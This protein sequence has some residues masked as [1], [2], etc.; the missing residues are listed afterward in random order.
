MR[1][2]SI[3]VAILAIG[4][5]S[6]LRAGEVVTL[7]PENFDQYIPAGKETDGL[8]GDLCMRND[9]IVAI[10]GKADRLR[11]ANM[12]VK[13]VGGM[14][15]DLTSRTDSNDQ[16]SAFYPCA[17]NRILTGPIDFTESKGSKEV[18][19]LRY[20]SQPVSGQPDLEVLYELKDGQ[21][22]ISVTTVYTNSSD[23]EIVIDPQDHIRADGECTTGVD[24]DLRLFWAQD[25][26]WGQAYGIVLADTSWQYAQDKRIL[27]Y[28]PSAPTAVSSKEP[29]SEKSAADKKENPKLPAQKLAA[30]QSLQIQ[31]WI[32]PASDTF[33]VRQKA[34]ELTNQT[35]SWKPLSIA[36]RDVK[37]PVQDCTIELQTS[38]GKSLAKARV[39]QLTSTI[40][41][42]KFDLSISAQGRKTVKQQ[43]DSTTASPLEIA[44]PLPGYVKSQITDE[45]GLPIACKCEIRGL[46][47]L[48]NPNFGPNSAIFGVGNLQYTPNGIFECELLPG[49]YEV[50][51]SHGL[52][53]DVATQRIEIAAGKTTSLQAKLVRSVKTPGWISADFHSH[54]S[55]SGD[56]TSNQRGRVL[57][58][59]SEHIEFAPC[60]E[61]N[62]ID[63]YEEHLQALEATNRMATCTG[64]ELTGSLLPVNHQNAFPLI[65]YPRTQ[66]NGG[67][68]TDLDPIAQIERLA[69]W[70][71][72]SDKLVQMNHPNLVQIIGDRDM[73]GKADGGFE[74]MFGFTDVIEVHP[75]QMIFERPTSL[76]ARDKDR[77]NPIF[78]WLQM[79]NL[80]YRITGVVNTDSHWNFHGSGWL[81]NYIRS[82]SDEPSQQDT[83]EL[84]HACEKGKVLMTNGPYLEVVGRCQSASG[85]QSAELGDTLS[86]SDGKVTLHIRVQCANWV[87]VNRVQVFVNGQPL[88]EYNFKP[89]THPKFFEAGSLVFDQQIPITVAG[90]AHLIVA[91]IGEGETLGFVAG[92]EHSK[93]PPVAVANPIFVDVDG[94]GFTANQDQLGLELPLQK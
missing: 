47:D 3:V 42:G 84:V 53:Y 39:N 30:G 58:L 18:A 87:K 71:K 7:T 52:E 80:G 34:A 32:F 82:T 45:N 78:H 77:G 1:C 36:I 91:T 63:S 56:N 67:P 21:N 92:P 54:S 57:N 12:T 51:V 81:R 70:D 60:T 48:P 74:K 88:P 27:R 37:G 2:F 10:F 29:S 31:R 66:D 44:L 40:P 9:K 73:D 65:R 61:H 50:I 86:T 90:D 6:N 8:P 22:A 17:P 93:D 4:N 59:L 83:L 85:P 79:L 62:R 26:F 20:R 5:L 41:P 94:N 76:P 68:V 46:N 35:P 64:M 14:L 25:L 72:G 89:A 28:I 55:P 69:M 33:A 15:I 23:K 11:N 13:N 43:I 49:A 19:R 75:P 38:E 24:Q 16:L